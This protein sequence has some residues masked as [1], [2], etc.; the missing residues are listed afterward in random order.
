MPSVKVEWAVLSAADLAGIVELAQRCRQHDGGL[1]ATAAPAFLE[2]RY[3]GAEVTALGAF[4]AG[5]LL[6]C[7]SVR[8][9][10]GAGAAVGLVD[11]GHRGHGLGARLLDQLLDLAKTWSDRLQVET[12]SLTPAADELFRSRGLEQTFAEDVYHRDLATPLPRV[13]L[14]AGVTA[15]EWT[16]DNQDAFYTAY[17]A[18]FADR[19]GFPGWSPGQWLDWLADDTFLPGCSLVARA[20]G[21][22]PVGFVT[23]GQEFLIQV[24]AVPRWRQRG[25]G[26]GLAVA[27][28]ERMRAGGGTEVFLDVNVNNPASAALFQG[29]GFSVVARRARYEPRDARTGH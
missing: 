19:P 13:P 29:L 11:P 3:T 16:E 12:E 24:G 18:S 23:C 15:E 21:G 10:R 26:R 9:W 1:Q 25:L 22:A 17:R 4:G 2:R 5:R 14:P 20:G 27:A 28:L 8:P 6:A 7:G